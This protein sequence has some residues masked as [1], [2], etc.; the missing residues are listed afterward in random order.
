M[1]RL[2]FS[3]ASVPGLLGLLL[4]F[5]AGSALGQQPSR[6]GAARQASDALSPIEIQRLFEAY[7][8]VQ[9][10]DALV[11]TDTQL[12]QFLSRLRVLQ[13]TRRR[14]QQER[15]RILQQLA[16]LSN[17]SGE[18]DEARVRAALRDLDLADERSSSEL[19]KA[20]EGL[21]QILDL[22][23]QARF[24]VFEDQMERRKFELLMRA[25]RGAARR[26]API[27]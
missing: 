19:R 17:P 12:P 13:E 1:K 3:R 2:S 22:R 25:R 15:N 16:R 14:N 6:A 7:E 8:S 11:L 26:A 27:K 4:I 5:S 10:Q 20:Y 23:Q 9:A 18:F 21:G 24:R